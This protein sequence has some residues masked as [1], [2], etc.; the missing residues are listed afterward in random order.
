MAL[1]FL[2]TEKSFDNV[3]WQFMLEQLKTTDE[4]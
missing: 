3:N 4:G 1:I 2:D